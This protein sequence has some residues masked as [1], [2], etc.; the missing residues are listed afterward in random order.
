MRDV[1]RADHQARRSVRCPSSRAYERARGDNSAM[2][3]PQTDAD[4]ATPNTWKVGREQASYLHDEARNLVGGRSSA[5]R[6]DLS[7]QD[8]EDAASAARAG[9]DPWPVL[10]RARAK[11]L[12]SPLGAV[13]MDFENHRHVDTD[14]YPT[15]AA[16]AVEHKAVEALSGYRCEAVDCVHLGDGSGQAPT[17]AVR[18]LKFLDRFTVF[19]LVPHV[20]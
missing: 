14:L 18:V 9:Y 16:V 11:Q 19:V 2:T 20:H 1:R 5:T 17:P 10:A 12:L 3:T 13:L 15:A 4:A 8:Y 6:E 7:Q